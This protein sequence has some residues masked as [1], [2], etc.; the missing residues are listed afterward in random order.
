MPNTISNQ[1]FIKIFVC[2]LSLIAAGC[3]ENPESRFDRLTA[4]G[5]GHFA[6]R[7]YTEAMIAWRTALDIHPQ[8]GSIHLKLGKASLKLANLKSAIEMFQIAVES[9][10]NQTETRI[11]L[12]RLLLISG[13][14]SNARPLI[15][16]LLDQFEDT[17]P[18]HVLK[19]DLEML[20]NKPA[21]AEKSYRHAAS[22][23][24]RIDLAL[25]KL[26]LSQQ[27]QKKSVDAAD[28][29]EKAAALNTGNVDTLMQF[30]HF[31]RLQENISQAEALLQEAIG[32][33]PE[34]LSLQMELSNFYIDT[35]Q[36]EAALTSLEKL[37]TILPEP[38]TAKKLIAET[39]MNQG[40]LAESKTILDQLN[41]SNTKDAELEM[42]RGKYHLLSSEYAAAIGSFNSALR[43]TPD[44]PSVLYLLGVTFLANGRNHLARKNL[45]QALGYDPYFTDAELLLANI[46]YKEKE[47][48]LGAEHARRIS[49]RE[50]ENFRAHQILG[51]IRAAQG[52]YDDALS[53]MSDS[54]KLYPE[55]PS[56]LYHTAIIMENMQKPMAA[57]ACYRRLLATHPDLIDAIS[58]YAAL[59][60]Q[61]NQT[62]EALKYV[63]SAINRDSECAQLHQILGEILLSRGEYNEAVHSLESAVE[64]APE[65]ETPYLQLAGIH[66]QM[67]NASDEKSILAACIEAVPSC[68]LAYMKLADV[69]RRERNLAAAAD[70]LKAGLVHNAEDPWLGCNLS[71]IYLEQNENMN[72]AFTFAQS[73]FEQ[74][75]NEAAAGDTL[76]WAFHKKG[77]HS[78]AIWILKETVSKAPKNPLI[79]YHLGMARLASGDISAAETNFNRATALGL[80]NPYLTIAKKAL[81]QEKTPEVVQDESSSNR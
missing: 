69:H 55:S 21:L 14:I 79:R 44:T 40:R 3:M 19:G 5:D 37:T 6:R 15:Q 43:I 50:P 33:E 11:E 72:E 65:T 34:D 4:E 29:Y 7:N 67:S 2:L 38:A 12:A 71:W 48:E 51:N 75:P 62:N 61:T 66:K 9:L 45:M 60:I 27:A 74:L 18:P 8:D 22:L 49:I 13:D 42:L 20:E 53:I 73:A 24:G 35:G 70:T 63:Q 58:R 30:Y 59:L 64:L 47:Y 32:L 1:T 54:Q 52:A 10:P 25:A 17:S 36:Y 78:Q 46:Y 77:F 16:S 57:L 81:A 23:G 26:S 41:G 39:L 76:G 56:P 68:R 31:R 28:T 80:E